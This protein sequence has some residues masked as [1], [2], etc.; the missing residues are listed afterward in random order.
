MVSVINLNEHQTWKKRSSSKV[1]TR[2]LPLHL[3]HIENLH[4]AFENRNSPQGWCGYA[5][6]D[7]IPIPF[8]TSLSSSKS[9]NRQGVILFF[10][11]SERILFLFRH[12]DK[13]FC[14]IETDG[15]I[16]AKKNKIEALV[17][18]LQQDNLI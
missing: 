12:P 14:L 6:V 2:V 1:L 13:K 11:T 4:H 5:V 7:Q 10:N 9:Q 16:V 3:K 8:K 15:K 17:K 18:N